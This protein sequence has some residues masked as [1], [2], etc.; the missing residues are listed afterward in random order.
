MGDPSNVIPSVIG[1]VAGIFSACCIALGLK[2]RQ[3]K[4]EETVVYKD[5][6]HACV[7]GIEGKIDGVK[8]TLRSMDASREKA[9]QEDL[10]FR[11]TLERFMGR[12]EGQLSPHGS[13]NEKN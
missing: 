2:S 12:M 8:E 13:R 6:C 10:E 11:G 3:D 9:R 4:L 1:S 7:K 5:T